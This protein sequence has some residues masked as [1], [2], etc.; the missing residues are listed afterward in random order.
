MQT[1]PIRIMSFDIG[2][3]NMAFCILERSTDPDDNI[4]ITDWQLID[5]STNN[6]TK[7]KDKEKEKDKD[8]D[9]EK[10][11]CNCNNKNNKLCGHI[12]K[13]YKN[14]RFFCEKHAMNGSYIKPNKNHDRKSLL[15]QKII[16]LDILGKIYKVF[17]D[18]NNNNNDDDDN[19]KK[20]KKCIM[21]DKLETFF[22]NNSLVA[23]Q[24]NIVIKSNE[25][26]LITIGRNMKQIFDTIKNIDTLTHIIIEN[27]IS[28]I[29]NRM[30]TIQGMLA[31]YF[32]MKL[33]DNVKISFISSQNKLKIFKQDPFIIVE[34]NKNEKK[35]SNNYNINKKKAIFYTMELVKNNKQLIHWS[36]LL[37]NKKKDDLSDCFLQGIWY[38]HHL[39]IITI[40]SNY[41][42]SIK[43]S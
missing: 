20:V 17:D 43:A 6:V 35:D 38:M 8:K 41:N 27:Q 32:I 12:A 14:D 5:L 7:D 25:I 24:K 28:P 29:A 31:Q 37:L 30:K 42:I 18:N 26:D 10:E 23:I 2:I 19:D 33:G 22:Q 16:D 21:V 34:P 1:Q 9:K 4:I 36:P 39:N 13:Y 11:K 15:R 3:K 40:L